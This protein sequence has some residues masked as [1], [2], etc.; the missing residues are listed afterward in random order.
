M[1]NYAQGIFVPTQPQKY[2]GKHNPKYRSGWEFT[3]MQF[4]DKNKN[5]IQWSSESIIIPYIHPLTGK[6][7]NY[8]PDF[9]VVYENKHGHQKAEIV[10]IKPKKQ[11]LIESRVAS[12]RDRAVVAI[13]HA[14]WASAMAF[15]RQNGLT[16]RVI[17]EDDL[18]YQGKRK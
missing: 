6:R 9:L 7:T 15:C 16:F 3:F 4:C 1:A 2:I 14:K 18:F 12:A 10:E 17:T 13:N 11:S 8:I 5:V